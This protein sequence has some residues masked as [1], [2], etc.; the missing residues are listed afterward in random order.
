MSPP[1]KPTFGAA[2]PFAPRPQPSSYTTTPIFNQ[3]LEEDEPQV[4]KSVTHPPFLSSLCL[5]IAYH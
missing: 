2:P 4:I 5:P 1:S 3:P